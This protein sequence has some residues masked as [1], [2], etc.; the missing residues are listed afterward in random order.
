MQL[1]SDLTQFLSFIATPV[2]GAWFISHFVET[3]P[4]IRWLRFPG[5]TA[6]GDTTKKL[7]T[8]VVYILLA[9][10]SA[11]LVKWVPASAIEALQPIYAII[12][13]SLGAWVSGS[14]F[15]YV[16]HTRKKNQAKAL[17]G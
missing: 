17:A 9:L 14:A 3:L 10:A 1:P 4:A 2:F 16:V 12:I 13:A 5:W 15:H 8:A 6:L 7:I 11:G